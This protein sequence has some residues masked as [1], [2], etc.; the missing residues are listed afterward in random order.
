MHPSAREH[1]K[2][3]A[4]SG[5]AEAGASASSGKELQTTTP[6]RRGRIVYNIDLT[7]LSYG[8]ATGSATTTSLLGAGPTQLKG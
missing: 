7:P 5:R 2:N 3:G 6:R 1:F 8:E 4:V